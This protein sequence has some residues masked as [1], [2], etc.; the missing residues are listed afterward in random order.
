MGSASSRTSEPFEFTTTTISDY[1]GQSVFSPAG[2]WNIPPNLNVVLLDEHWVEY[3]AF[4]NINN[5]KVA[6]LPIPSQERVYI[7]FD[8]Y[9]LAFARYIDDFG[10]TMDESSTCPATY[11]NFVRMR[12]TIAP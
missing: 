1:R 3:T 5:V 10:W 6:I 11:D 8:G 7:F 2:D 12:A 9:N 4:E